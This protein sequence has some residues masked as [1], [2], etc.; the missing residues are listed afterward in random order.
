MMT[1][2]NV[3][4]PLAFQMP[5]RITKDSAWVEHTPFAMNL[6]AL[7]RPRTIVELGTH[8]GDSYCAF[9][10]AVDSLGCDT[11]CFAV[12]TWKGDP[13]SGL[14]G[15]EIL[16]DL[17]A[18][19]DPNYGRFSRLVQNTFQ[20]ALS[21]FADGSIDLLHIDGYHTYQQVKAD[22][23]AWSVKLS[24]SAVVLLHD[25]NVREHGFGIWQFWQELRDG[26]P[27]FEFL[28]GHGLGLVT[29]GPA[30]PEALSPLFTADAAKSQQ[31]REIFFALG[32]RVAF[33]KEL[34]EITGLWRSGAGELKAAEEGQMRMKGEVAGLERE[35]AA[36]RAA[37]TESASEEA[38]LLDELA[39]ERKLREQADAQIAVQIR[40]LSAIV[41]SRSWR[42]IQN[43]RRARDLVVSRAG[44]GALKP[45][46]GRLRKASSFYRDHGAQATWRKTMQVIQRDL[47]P[48]SQPLVNSPLPPS[49][50][51]P[52]SGSPDETVRARFPALQPLRLFTSPHPE[53]RVNLVTDSINS[54]WLFGGVGTAMVLGTLLAERR[55]ASL[56]VVTRNEPPEPGNFQRVLAA[57]NI[58][59]HPKVDF[60]FLQVGNSR[61]ALDIGDQDVFLTTSWWTTRS[62]LDSV[63]EKRVI[64]L[65]QEDERMFYPLG[66][67]HL[68]ASELLRHP[69]LRI[70]VNSKILFDHLVADGHENIARLGLWFEPSFPAKAFY[71]E[72]GARRD[73]QNFLFYA[74]P[75]NQRNLFYRGIEAIDAAVAR[76]IL[77]LT[78]W[79]LFFVGKDLPDLRIN[80]SYKPRLIQT[81]PWGEY[82]ALVRS[83]D[84][85]L[86]LMYTPHPSY[87]PLDLAASGAV[88]VTNRFG[89]KLDLD[90]YS[91]NILCRDL[92]I[93]SL[94]Q[95]I[96]DGVRLAAD[97]ITRRQNYEHNGILRDWRVSFGEV[98][99]KLERI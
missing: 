79:E 31:I 14:Y 38:R 75:H 32:Q 16:A 5:R 9:C 89:P 66:D 41:G 82:A 17:R 37:Q 12:D 52:L 7:L 56:R 97:T 74:R 11:R 71:P 64:Y 53:P 95:G 93:E 83:M 3:L 81:L 49:V 73:K 19:H 22:Y 42:L 60:A 1:I 28:H 45:L 48:T 39:Q 72:W 88:A 24:S 36:L 78:Q 90:R 55:K 44:V 59:C 40:D 29:P 18:H 86:C 6:V 25:T 13:H 23:E 26:R 87:P 63:G 54:A 77:D 58:P 50:E 91:P 67:E 20:E 76:G 69:N 61:H 57:N 94:V 34:N 10:Q 92:E 47:A 51:T 43:Y 4:H 84:L 33:A 99:S 46:A 85:G 65:L 70:V 30:A 2:S 8:S 80:G 68:R 21:Q 35:A 15:P 96:G 62:V 27:S 98:L